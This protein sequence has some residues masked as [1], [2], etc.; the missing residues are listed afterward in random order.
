MSGGADAALVAARRGAADALRAVR[1]G[2]ALATITGDPP[3]AARGIRV[4][5]VQV[6]PDG[7]RLA[8]LLADGAISLPGGTRYSLEHGAA[9]LARARAGTHGEPVVIEPGGAG[10]GTDKEGLSWRP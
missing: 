7:A 3:G 9:A 1:S 8:R 6:A 4:T 10:D 5:A 2:G